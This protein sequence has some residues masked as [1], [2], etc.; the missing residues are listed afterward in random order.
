MIFSASARRALRIVGLGVVSCAGMLASL[1]TWAVGLP[2]FD[3]QPGLSLGQTITF[4]A[5]ADLVGSTAPQAL[6]ANDI[7]VAPNGSLWVAS[8]HGL[9][10]QAGFGWN[11]RKVTTPA[12]GEA[13]RAETISVGVRRVDVDR[14]TGL[15]WIVD[16][17]NNLGVREKDG[18]WRV[19]AQSVQDFGI[20]D[21]R[22]WVI[23]TAADPA[24]P[25]ATDGAILTGTRDKYDAFYGWHDHLGKPTAIDVAADGVAW[26]TTSYGLI[27]RSHD[28]D[29]RPGRWTVQNTPACIDPATGSAAGCASAGSSLTDVAVIDNESAW[30]TG[31]ERAGP[32]VRLHTNGLRFSLGITDRRALRALGTDDRGHLAALTDTGVPITVP[33]LA[34]MSA[35]TMESLATIQNQTERPEQTRM[36]AF[37]DGALPVSVTIPAG[38]KPVDHAAALNPSSDLSMTFSILPPESGPGAGTTPQCVLALRSSQRE[39]FSICLDATQTSLTVRIGNAERV[40]P[41]SLGGLSRN[42]KP[43]A[44]RF[45]LQTEADEARLYTVDETWK[46]DATFG[47]EVIDTAQVRTLTTFSFRNTATDT[48]PTL[49]LH[50]GG[51]AP[52]TDLFRGHI[53]PVRIW[54]SGNID[55]AVLFAAHYAGRWANAQAPAPLDLV[56]DAPLALV[57]DKAPS[58]NGAD[59]VKLLSPVNLSGLWYSQER[60]GEYDQVEMSASRKSLSYSARRIE[61]L[62]IATSRADP[63]KPNA[64]GGVDIFRD[65][66]GGMVET[67][68]IQT[69][70]DTFAGWREPAEGRF[71]AGFRPFDL[72]V[73]AGGDSLQVTD[74]NTSRTTTYKRI[75]EAS[76]V[77][78]PRDNV[79][80]PF[81]NYVGYDLE[82]SWFWDNPDGGTAGGATNPDGSRSGRSAIFSNRPLD[83]SGQVK[84]VP[85]GR[86]I[87][88]GLLYVPL[89]KGVSK[90][91][92]RVIETTRELQD[93]LRASLGAGADMP[94]VFSFSA[95]AEFEATT[96]RMESAKSTLAIGDLWFGGYGLVL[97]PGRISLQPDFRSVVESAAAAAPGQSRAGRIDQLL[98]T[99]GTHYTNFVVFGCSARYERRINEESMSREIEKQF[100]V[101][102]KS[103]GTISGVTINLEGAFGRGTRSMFE[104]SEEA[105][106]TEIY[107]Q[108]ATV[109]F[110]A[111]EVTCGEEIV[112]GN[113]ISRDLRPITDLL[114]PIHFDSPAVYRELRNA[115]GLRALERMR[116]IPDRVAVSDS[117][118]LPDLYVVTLESLS[119][120]NLGEDN[121]VVG[122]I[123]LS[124][125]PAGARKPRSVSLFNEVAGPNAPRPSAA[126]GASITIGKRVVLSAGSDVS[127]AQLIAR[128]TGP[129]STSALGEVTQK[130]DLGQARST[131][132][133]AAEVSAISPDCK[134]V[135][136]CPDGYLDEEG[137]CL[138]AC[139]NGFDKRGR[140]CYGSY[141]RTFYITGPL[142]MDKCKEQN[143][144]KEC[145]QEDLWAVYVKCDPNFVTWPFGVCQPK[146]EA[147]GLEKWGGTNVTCSRPQASRTLSG[148]S[149]SNTCPSGA[150]PGVDCARVGIA[151]SVEKVSYEE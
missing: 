147:F 5:R 146:C 3:P 88:W 77:G 84:D 139:P 105:K 142:G 47:I 14:K 62:R 119:P 151:F 137:A 36:R 124:Y 131:G 69:G 75:P 65:G 29:G 82:R 74:P 90:N 128:L 109:S 23:P 22:L 58:A 126:E 112:R 67:R 97:D 31:V 145:Y 38:G 4:D 45:I 9:L 115:V 49:R 92:E 144:S 118:V 28:D 41:V 27:V 120:A 11:V 26:I 35:G 100:D 33:L 111:E 113:A 81:D 79:D 110:D 150:T 60:E 63:A 59:R 91:T 83:T 8:D 94:E 101:E 56:L 48:S 136:A 57:D 93:D 50:I 116:A 130:L 134:C 133:Y 53:G 104:K 42:G 52:D 25:R 19:V 73:V 10:E 72:K 17:N 70:S 12:I 7:D 32:F 95:S 15:I 98:D 39:T 138:K 135:T 89:D 64:T 108:G 125:T 51:R 106:N 18:M 132:M 76:T 140:T 96:E 66:E 117:R 121:V 43:I 80:Q 107:T 37:G 122:S 6:K 46:K 20:H 87:P 149:P 61:V 99:Y 78:G 148:R 34:T 21:G 44:R 141:S 71:P 16:S 2:A 30:V 127:D 129:S 55:P 68:F 114:S 24:R 123:N 13:R 85:S 143:P 1:S 86:K 102:A 54:R 103:S 40:V